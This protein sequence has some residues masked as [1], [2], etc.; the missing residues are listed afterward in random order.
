MTT[1]PD[2]K[3]RMSFDEILAE[4]E[5]VAQNG[6]GADKFRALKILMAQE[7]S[8]VT[9]PPPMSDAE[10][11]DRLA[12][13][14]R[15]AGPT[16][17]QLAYRRAYPAAKRPINHSAPKIQET[18]VAP[19][20]KTTLPANLRALYR[21]FPEVKR[22]GIPKGYPVHQGMA[23]QKKWCQEAALKMIIDREQAKHDVIATEA[24]DAPAE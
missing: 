22:G 11:I 5:D 8:S 9:L 16:A 6:D 18:D 10:V 12:R 24:A 13:L 14:I 1:G 20:D 19:V 23:V 4:I 3:K 17:S 21:M 15:A 2:P 7:S